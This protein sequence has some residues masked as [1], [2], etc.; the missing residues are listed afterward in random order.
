MGGYVM[1]GS[2]MTD[3]FKKIYKEHRELGENTEKQLLMMI[4]FSQN[5]S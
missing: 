3:M 5:R 4:R 1:N 2:K